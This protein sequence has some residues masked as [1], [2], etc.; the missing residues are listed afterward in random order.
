M[1]V[2]RREFLQGSGTVAAAALAGMAVTPSASAQ[3][4]TRTWLLARDAF[5][6][7][8]NVGLAGSPKVCRSAFNQGQ[9]WFSTRYASGEFQTT[10][11][12]AGYTGVGV[13]KFEAYQNGSTGLVDAI[14]AGLPSWVQAVQYDP[15][16]WSF[17][18]EIEQGA[19]LYNT[20]AQASYAQRFC[21]TA[22]QHGLRVVLTPA[23]DLCNRDPNPAYPN[24]A[25]QYPLDSHDNGEDYNA[26]LR[27]QLGTAAHYL[28]AGDV[29]EYQS[30][31]LEL[32][33]RTYHAI[34]FRAS[35]QV[36]T[37]AP[38]GVTFLAGLGHSMPPGD[39]ATCAQLTAAASSVANITAGFWLN[40]GAYTDQVRPM[41]CALKSLGY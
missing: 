26:Y 19:L 38:A 28:Q 23:N 12:P 4:A 7:L 13:L 39:G 31:Q 27:H 32:D 17:T 5:D 40:V 15:E 6:N 11:V 24:S 2:T 10:P 36:A 8:N 20:Y 22:H 14:A 18:P 41:I 16:E 1:P 3:P 9:T 34:T 30:Q 21:V 25:P 35:Q 29:F 33:S 37:S